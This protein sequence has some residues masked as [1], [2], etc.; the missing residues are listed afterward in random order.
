METDSTSS[1]FWT[2]SIPFWSKEHFHWNLNSIVAS[3][4]M[5]SFWDFDRRSEIWKHCKKWVFCRQDTILLANVAVFELRF[6]WWWNNFNN[7]AVAK[8]AIKWM[9]FIDISVESSES[10]VARRKVFENQDGSFHTTRLW[11]FRTIWI[12]MQGQ[13]SQ[14]I[15]GETVL[16]NGTFDGHCDGRNHASIYEGNGFEAKSR[17]I[18]LKTLLQVWTSRLRHWCMNSS[19]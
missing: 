11:N 7:F 17:I 12:L 15:H 8:F 19:L 4:K 14:T 10:V 18:F 3:S 1:S 16:Q 5:V 2:I 9:L 6:F 13:N